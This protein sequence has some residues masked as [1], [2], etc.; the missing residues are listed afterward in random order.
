MMP[1]D[2]R[3]RRSP[4]AS[5]PASSASIRRSGRSSIDASSRRRGPSPCTT[6]SPAR[7]L[8]RQTYPP[9]ATWPA[10]GC[11]ARRCT[12]RPAVLVHDAQ[13]PQVAPGVALDH[14]LDE[15]APRE[16]LLEQHKPVDTRGTG[17]RTT[18]WRSRR[19]RAD[20]RNE[21]PAESALL[22]VAT[23]SMPVRGQRAAIEKV[24]PA[25][26]RT[27]AASGSTPSSA[28]RAVAVAG[29]LSRLTRYSDMSMPAD[30]PAAVMTLPS[31]TQRS[32]STTSCRRRVPAAPWIAPQWV[33]ARLPSRETRRCAGRSRR[34]RRTSRTRAA[35]RALRTKSRSFSLF[36]SVRVPRPPGTRITSSGGQS[37]KLW[38]A[39]ERVPQEAATGPPSSEMRTTFHSPP[40]HGE[41]SERLRADG[42][43]VL[44]V[45]KDDAAVL[46]FRI[47]FLEL[48]LIR[49]ANWCL[50]VRPHP[51][52][53]PGL[54]DQSG[55]LS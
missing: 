48:A 42:V 26:L 27:P 40:G 9:P 5:W 17:S 34:C 33:V 20:V 35:R 36:I 37:S 38:S 23:P 1:A 14:A 39:M 15:R 16:A 51:P 6:S 47:T 22:D 29:S 28:G 53:L 54:S 8:P 11:S 45:R 12:R 10:H 52:R 30:T 21:A 49:R 55:S 7:M 25:P 44:E 50:E 3:P 4:P 2:W 31:C 19:R 41:H 24:T 32:S 43:Q 46:S 18:G 13:L